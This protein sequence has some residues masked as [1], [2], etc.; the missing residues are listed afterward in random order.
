MKN[1][2]ISII[3]VVYNRH[4]VIK[5]C[6]HSLKKQTYKNVEHIIIDGKSNDGTL[7][8]IK[9]NS[10]S[11]TILVSEEDEG[12]YDALNKGLDLCTG[13]IVGILH[14]DDTYYSTNVLAQTAYHLSRDKKIDGVYGDVIY[15]AAKNRKRIIR[16]LTSEDLSVQNIKKGSFPGHTSLFLKLNEK[17]KNMR[18]NTNYKIAGDFDYLVKLLKVKNIKLKSTG[19]ITS[20]MEW[21]GV[22]TSGLWSYLK[23]SKEMVCSLKS[24]NIIYSNF[25]IYSRI[26]WKI[27]Q[28]CFFKN[29]SKIGQ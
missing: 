4:K 2:K 25:L 28:L 14:S 29:F 1:P 19:T 9:K 24:N 23:I 10:L 26:F 20:M 21:G 11:N 3:T 12:I 22:S 6:I 7:E 16:V 5:R 17:T 8:I 15:V 13:D 27:K 18:Y